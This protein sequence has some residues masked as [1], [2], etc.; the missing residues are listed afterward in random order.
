MTFNSNK[1]EKEQRMFGSREDLFTEMRNKALKDDLNSRAESKM[2]NPEGE[3]EKKG[4]DGLKQASNRLHTL[5]KEQSKL[6][7]TMET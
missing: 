1:S 7:Q 5:K 4:K 2:D 3:V 6:K